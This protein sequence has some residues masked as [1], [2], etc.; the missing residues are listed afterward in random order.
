MA[1]MSVADIAAVTRANDG[2]ADG[3]GWGGGGFIWIFAIL[4][5]MGGGFGGWNNNRGG[6]VTEADLCNANSF[7]DLKSSVRN[8]SDQISGMNI[9]LTKGLCDLGYTLFGQFSAMERQLSDCCCQILRGIDSIKFD[10]ANYAAATNQLFT[11][12]IQSVKDMF[13]DY[14]EANLRDQNMKQYFQSQLCGVV[15]Y[16]TAT[17]Y[18]TSCNPFFGGYNYGCGSCANI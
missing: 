7:N 9:G 10:M 2:C 6:C 13:R 18:A 17:T 14:Q 1:D 11:A 3:F 12:G 15:R 16:P 4:A 8:V 5:L